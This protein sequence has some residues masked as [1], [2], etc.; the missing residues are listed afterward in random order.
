MQHTV[1]EK[2]FFEPNLIEII[3]KYHVITLEIFITPS[4]QVEKLS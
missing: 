3:Q 2:R 4:G 1:N